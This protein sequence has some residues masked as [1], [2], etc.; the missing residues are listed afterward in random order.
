MVRRDRHHDYHPCLRRN[1]H[2]K[3]SLPYSYPYPNAVAYSDA[4][5][6]A[7]QRWLMTTAYFTLAAGLVFWAW[8]R[9]H[10]AT[11][12]A[13]AAGLFMSIL[14]IFADPFWRMPY[15]AMIDS[16]IVV[17]MLCL[18]VRYHSMRAWS[19]GAIGMA[20]TGLTFAAYVINPYAAS[21]AYAIALNAAFL[22]QVLVAGG[23]CDGVGRWL[24]NRLLRAFPRRHGL[25]RN[26]RP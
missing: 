22:L 15:A 23:F 14:A 1:Y 18:W 10:D 25:L 17:T 5:P 21:W 12:T 6:C 24:D 20:K 26:G 3:H 2:G 13:L 16:V 8:V 9:K 11:T 19:V 7:V 4:Y